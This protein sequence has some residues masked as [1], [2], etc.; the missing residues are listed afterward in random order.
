V[1]HL[2]HLLALLLFASALPLL[3]QVPEVTGGCAQA[4]GTCGTGSG[5]SSSSGSSVH[6]MNA[7]ER[8]HH[9]FD[10][11]KRRHEKN[12][13]QV[14]HLMKMAKVRMKENN[15]AQ[16]IDDLN[17]CMH[18]LQ[19][20]S[21]GGADTSYWKHIPSSQVLALYNDYLAYENKVQKEINEINAE[22]SAK[23][24]A[25]QQ[26][27]R[28]QQLAAQNL[29]NNNHPAAANPNL[30]D[31]RS[32]FVTNN[33]GT[34]MQQLQS[35]AGST[36]QG[37]APAVNATC[38][39]QRGSGDWGPCGLPASIST[40]KKAQKDIKKISKEWQEKK[41][42]EDLLLERMTKIKTEMKTSKNPQKLSDEY[43]QLSGKQ[44]QIHSEEAAIQ[45]KLNNYPITETIN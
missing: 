42:Q 2:Q 21:Q 6:H 45:D 33:N 32:T 26:M 41:N 25:Q 40:N 14:K 11:A 44:V 8:E 19:I 1:R 10:L 28:Q 3:A 35:A 27:A 5:S 23:Q 13:E 9:Q 38:V 37:T 20:W 29:T 16:A 39:L 18:N 22:Q 30:N 24:Q 31:A 4:S 7:A 17:V 43:N 15:Y 36:G 34:A 12:V